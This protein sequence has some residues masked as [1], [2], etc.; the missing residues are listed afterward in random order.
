MTAPALV[1]AAGRRIARR[2]RLATWL[3]RL[4]ALVPAAKLRSRLYRSLSWPLALG[5][6]AET[7]VTVAGGSR[8]L[9]RT[10]DLVGRVLAISGVW[11]PNV[12]VAFERAL[13]RGDVCLDVGAH[14]GYYTLLAAKLVGP[15]GHVYAFEPSPDSF[16]ALHEN[17]ELNGLANVTAVALAVGEQNGRAVLYEGPGT[18]SGLATL[19]TALAA[20]ST[21][22]LREVT[23]DVGPITSVVPPEEL[24]RVRVIKIDVEW[25]EVEVLRS[26]TPVFDLGGRLSVFVEWTH[27]RSAP[28]LDDY[29]RHLCAAQGFALYGLPSGYSLERLFPDR[30]DHPAALDAVPLEQSDLLLVR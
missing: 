20:K 14:I 22:P 6:A 11:E 30:L 7:E 9:V 13:A 10:D 29:L 19:S 4:P 15:Q 12:T 2:P 16:R 18:N 27:R 1:V 26:L 23:V 17:I 25:Q 28:Q 3:M 24:V 21:T 8:M 5:H